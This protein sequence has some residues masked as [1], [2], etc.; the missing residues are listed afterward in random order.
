VNKFGGPHASGESKVPELVLVVEGVTMS[1]A[2]PLAKPFMSLEAA[3]KISSPPSSSWT[4][5][6]V[7]DLQEQVGASSENCDLEDEINPSS[8]RCWSGKSK[9]IQIDLAAK[10]TT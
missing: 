6:L 5:K 3:F 7:K 4:R 8:T 1:T 10:V 9:I 2:L